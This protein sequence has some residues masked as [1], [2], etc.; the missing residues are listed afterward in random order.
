M[1]SG[2]VKRLCALLDLEVV[3]ESGEG[4]GRAFDF[5]GDL[6][7][8]SLKLTG[9]FVG[10]S[11]LRERLGAS[12]ARHKGSGDVIPWDSV[13]RIRAGKIVVRDDAAPPS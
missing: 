10:R 5:H 3:T 4:L 7:A 11:G 12:R 9:I 13:V 8:S 2:L 1:D 6:Q